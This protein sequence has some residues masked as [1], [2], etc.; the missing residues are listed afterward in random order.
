MHRIECPGCGHKLRYA[1]VRAGKKAK[2]QKCGHS[3]R[4]PMLEA[5]GVADGWPPARPPRKPSALVTFKCP[6]C[7]KPVAV[8]T[9]GK[10]ANMTSGPP[11]AIGLRHLFT[12]VPEKPGEAGLA[13]LSCP[14][15]KQSYPCAEVL[16][17]RGQVLFN[18]P[19]CEHQMLLKEFRASDIICCELCGRGFTGGAIRNYKGIIEPVASPP[20]HGKESLHQRAA[21]SRSIMRASKTRTSTSSRVGATSDTHTVLT[22]KLS[23]SV[24]QP[25]SESRSYSRTC[26][27]CGGK[28]TFKVASYQQARDRAKKWAMFGIVGVPF[29]LGMLSG[30]VRRAGPELSGIRGLSGAAR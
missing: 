11:Q 12:E 29:F 2:C 19:S 6:R 16:A 21:R 3:V 9:L 27:I 26:P 17:L 24:L 8:D 10:L 18:C 1:D 25:E 28:L 20:E 4:L 14:H 15:C 5:P 13:P 7:H 30:P 23:T 22:H